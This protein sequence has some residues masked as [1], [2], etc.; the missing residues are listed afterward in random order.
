[1]RN[2]KGQYYLVAAI[3]IILAVSGIAS[4][5]TYASVKSE[6]RKIQDIGS[7]LREETVRI[8]DYGVYS[9]DNLTRV[10][11]NFTDSEFA[12]YFLKKTDNTSIVF[13]YGDAD[14]LY[15]VQYKPEHTGDVYATLG[16]A[17]PSWNEITIYANRTRLTGFGE[18]INVTILNRN[19]EFEIRNNEMFY[20][21]ITQEKE[22]EVYIERN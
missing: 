14:E 10:L 11:N 19:F 4:V 12:P 22:G 15:S 13:I 2:K 21:L 3:I 20:F 18:T 1:M 5:K 16:G 17:S 6:P 8:V 7:E 9:K